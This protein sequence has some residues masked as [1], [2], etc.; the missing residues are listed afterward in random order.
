MGISSLKKKKDHHNNP[1]SGSMDLHV[2]QL[3]LHTEDPD[4]LENEEGEINVD[5]DGAGVHWA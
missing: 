3:A 2:N 5:A 4:T 1:V